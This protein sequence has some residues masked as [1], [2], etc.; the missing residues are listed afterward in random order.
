MKQGVKN[1]AQNE[2]MLKALGGGTSEAAI[3]IQVSWKL[4]RNSF[5]VYT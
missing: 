5:T 4:G 3:D 1:L 2:S